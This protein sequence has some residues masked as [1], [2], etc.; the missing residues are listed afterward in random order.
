MIRFLSSTILYS[1]LLHN[2]INLICTLEEFETKMN[3][4]LLME[5]RDMQ[6]EL[7]IIRQ[8][9]HAHPE[10][11]MEEK[12]TSTLVA[13]KLKQWDLTVTEGVGRFGVVG[14]LTS[15]KPCNRS[16]G[17]RADMDALQL[18]ERNNATYISTK[19]GAMHACGHDG[20]TAMLLGAAKYLSE[21]R[22]SFCGTV[23]FIF[24]PGEE[25]L[26]GA[27]AMINDSLFE[28]FPVDAIYGLH[29]VPEQMGTFSIRPGPLMAASD[30]W[31]VTFRG[32]VDHGGA[33]AHL[34]TDVTVLQAQFI[35]ALQT[36]V[37]RNINA[38][39]SAVI[40]VGA[41]QSGSFVSANVM[42]S[43]IRIGG[44][45]R[46][47][48]ASVRDLIEQ[49]INELATNLA[50]A[51]GCTAHVEYRRGAITLVNHD[52]QTKR[53]IKAAEAVVGSTNVTKNREPLMASEDF[54]FMLLKRPGAF[55]FMG[56]NDGAV[57]NK[58]H[59]PDYNFNDDAI[60]YGVAY[61]ISL[62]QQELND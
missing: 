4:S 27:I 28:R 37:S 58:L 12:R 39:D 26:A 59:S 46:T 51:F 32:T 5:V 6:A 13:S 20:H 1:I 43:E 2:Q 8:D 18:I 44:T 9:I 50:T 21:H 31:N 40:S 57:L 15:V 10:M 34:G 61:W 14:T 29:N 45:A 30:R 41:I 48:T 23:Q 49:R 42:P 62:V 56:N 35:M 3:D 47:L 33:G 52:E 7:A 17:L 19:L 36:I 22:D 16:I 54:A 25:R 11:A 53:A 38:I 24:Q 55:I 60:P